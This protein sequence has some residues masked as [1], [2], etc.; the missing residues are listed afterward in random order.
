MTES[1]NATLNHDQQPGKNNAMSVLIRANASDTDPFTLTT[2][3]QDSTNIA[4]GTGG[5]EYSGDSYPVNVNGIVNMDQGQY[6]SLWYRIKLEP[7][8]SDNTIFTAKSI[9]F[10]ATYLGKYE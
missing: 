7:Q 8:T 2:A 6:L 4:I 3:G 1:N 9:N 5:F 10:A